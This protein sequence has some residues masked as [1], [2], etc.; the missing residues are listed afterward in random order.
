MASLGWKGLRKTPQKIKVLV[1]THCLRAMFL[2]QQ[3]SAI[4]CYP[5]YQI[6][7][8]GICTPVKEPFLYNPTN[9]LLYER[10]L[11]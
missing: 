3:N 2:L 11:C 8:C 10:G 1:L 6:N 5:V 7:N 9:A 4:V